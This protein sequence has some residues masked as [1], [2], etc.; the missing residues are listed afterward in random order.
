VGGAQINFGDIDNFND[1]VDPSHPIVAGLSSP[2]EGNAA[3][4]TTVSNLP[5]G[6]LVIT[7]TSG[8]GQPTTVEY[9]F[10]S[11]TVI[12]TGMT[13]EYLYNFGYEAGAM[14]GN[15]VAYSLTKAG[16]GWLDV[17]RCQCGFARQIHGPRGQ[18]RRDLYGGD[19]RNLLSVATT[20]QFA[21]REHGHIATGAPT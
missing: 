6:A 2:L 9:D 10:G 15:A 5:G 8:S 16:V 17:D 1:I 7:E 3:N 18:V 4:H 11:G 13:W 21:G 12:A 14:L 19:T 20:A